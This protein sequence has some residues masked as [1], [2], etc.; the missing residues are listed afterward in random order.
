MPCS[1]LVVDRELARR[2]AL[3]AHTLL[4][5]LGRFDVLF[6]K[7]VV[8]GKERSAV[9]DQSC[10]TPVGSHLGQSALSSTLDLSAG[11]RSANPV[12]SFDGSLLKESLDQS[13]VGKLVAVVVAAA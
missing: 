1:D 6:G 13:R 12:T 11:T 7:E 2:W 8:E 9:L 3:C 10:G 5:L 4:D